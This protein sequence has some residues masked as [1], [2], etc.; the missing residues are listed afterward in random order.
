MKNILC[1][2]ILINLYYIKVHTHF[3]FSF[4]LRYLLNTEARKSEGKDKNFS[5][6]KEYRIYMVEKVTINYIVICHVENGS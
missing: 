4:L 5:T 1:T 3:L 6:A 2:T